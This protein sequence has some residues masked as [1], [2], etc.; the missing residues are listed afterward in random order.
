MPRQ[1][2]CHIATSVFSSLLCSTH[3]AMAAFRSAFSLLRSS[4]CGV[5]EVTHS[6]SS[7]SKPA[8]SGSSC[9]AHLNE[10]G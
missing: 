3:W 1:R 8:L 5:C 7:R 4:H 6:C 10:S 9:Q 2:C